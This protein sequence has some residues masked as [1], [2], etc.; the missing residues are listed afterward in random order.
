MT[1]SLKLAGS[2]LAVAL[3]VAGLVACGSKGSDSSSGAGGGDIKA[4]PGVTATTIKLGALTDLS[5][6]FAPLAEPL[7]LANQL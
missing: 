3:V 6:V 5:G 7:T 4:G 1:R 2:W